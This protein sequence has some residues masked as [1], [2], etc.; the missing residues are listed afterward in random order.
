MGVDAAHLADDDK[1]GIDARISVAHKFVDLE[2]KGHAEL[3]ETL[4]GGPWITPVPF[5][6][7]D[8]ITVDPVNYAREV[9][10]DGDFVRVGLSSTVILSKNCL[11]PVPKILAPGVGEFK[12]YLTD[13]SFI[14]ANYRGGVRPSERI[15]PRQRHSGSHSHHCGAVTDSQHPASID[16]LLDRAVQALNSGDRATADAL[17][18]QVLAVDSS[19]AEAEELLAAPE[20]S[21]EIRRLTILFVDL[22]DS[23]ALSTRIEPEISR[24]VVGR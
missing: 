13:L 4:I 15:S 21:G 11:T 7:Y 14:G 10:I 12:L 19:N 22:V 23:T 6:D 3:L 2:V 8:T 16:E 18:E 5:E 17:A 9:V 1:L 24:T 20:D